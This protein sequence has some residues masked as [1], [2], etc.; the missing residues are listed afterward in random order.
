MNADQA[1]QLCTG[2]LLSGLTGGAFVTIQL[3]LADIS[4]DRIRGRLGTFLS[5]YLNAG[6]LLGYIAGT[7]LPYNVIPYA[8]VSCPL[9][10]IGLFAFVPSTPQ[11]LL[12]IGD[13]VVSL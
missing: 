11:H 12:A 2:R 8:M 13:V 10:F 7:Y 4:D 9:A 3:F 1:W 6:V 5:L